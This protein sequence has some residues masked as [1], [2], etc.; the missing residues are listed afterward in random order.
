MSK[1]GLLLL[2]PAG[3]FKDVGS[4]L[5][6][7]GQDQ[8]T[9][10]EGKAISAAEQTSD[11]RVQKTGRSMALT[12]EDWMTESSMVKLSTSERQKARA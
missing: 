1:L 11:D 10:S 3:S 7:N 5:E 4:V 12:R 9:R 6:N 8:R 2:Q